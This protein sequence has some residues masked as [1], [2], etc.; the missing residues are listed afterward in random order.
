MSRT[1]ILGSV[2]TIGIDPGKNTFHLVGLDARGGVTL[3]EKVSRIKIAARLANV[4]RCL[5]GI[6]AGMATHYVACELSALGHDVK[7]VPPAYAKPFRQTHKNDFRDAL[8]VAEAVQCPTTLFVP[9]KSDAQ[10]DLQALHRVRTR[11][12]GERTAVINQIR[13]F[14]LERGV[15]VRQGHHFLRKQLPDILAQRTDVI[16]PRMLRIL[17]DLVGDWRRLDERIEAV[18]GEIEAMA[19]NDADYQRLMSV[20]GVGPIIASAMVA[21]RQRGGVHQRTELRRLAGPCAKADVDRRQDDSREDHPAWQQLSAHALHPGG[22]VRPAASG[23]LA[24]A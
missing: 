18:S 16:S 21:H 20:P 14:L 17:E 11:L 5:I 2:K 19:R 6:E 15:A 10:L 1:V 24:E 7:Q 9:A 23:E 3:R 4:P 8:A 22:S 12:V 13:G